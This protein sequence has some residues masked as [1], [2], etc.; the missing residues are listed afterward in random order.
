M[1]PSKHEAL[2]QCWADVGPSSTT[3]AQHQPNIGP[4]PRVCWDTAKSV[5]PQMLARYITFRGLGGRPKSKRYKTLG[6]RIRG[7]PSRKLANV[8]SLQVLSDSPFQGTIVG[9]LSADLN[10]NRKA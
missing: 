10:I 7:R 4:I 9:Y 6:Q 2:A 5:R 8:C 1:Y 3:L